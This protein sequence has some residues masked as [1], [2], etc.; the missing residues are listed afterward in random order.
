MGENEEMEQMPQENV[1]M[2]PQEAQPQEQV[3]QPTEAPAVNSQESNSVGT[4]QE[5]AQMCEDYEAKYN[6]NLIIDAIAIMESPNIQQLVQSNPEVEGFYNGLGR[7][8]PLLQDI[9][10]GMMEEGEA[11]PMPEEPKQS[12]KVIDFDKIME[13]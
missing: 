12:A 4:I 3:A 10:N 5:F 8:F 11:E 7:F 6:R 1:E 9:M 13:G 2:Q